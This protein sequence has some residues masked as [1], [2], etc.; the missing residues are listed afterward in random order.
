M[1]P[2]LYER[3]VAA[4]LGWDNR[5]TDSFADTTAAGRELSS[6]AMAALVWAGNEGSK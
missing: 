5:D 4:L 1:P 6:A 2:E 3:L